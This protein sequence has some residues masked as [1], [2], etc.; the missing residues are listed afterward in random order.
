MSDKLNDS[1]DGKR[2]NFNE[3]HLNEMILKAAEDGDLLG[4]KWC[5]SRDQS[6]VMAVDSDL[7]TPLHRSAYNNH[8]EV[9]RLLIGRGAD[10]RARTLDGWTPLHCASK[11]ANTGAADLLINCGADINAVSDG[12]NTA[13]HLAA[14]HNN[15]QL[16]ELFLHNQDID[17]TLTND[18]GETAYQIAKRSSPLHQLWQYL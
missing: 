14:S 6:V 13:L 16:L 5:L 10:V 3:L 1:L 8:T 4:V 7:Y 11:W 15:R 2:N 12:G 18:S 9:M 17:I